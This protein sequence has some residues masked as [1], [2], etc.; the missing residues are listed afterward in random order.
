MTSSSKFPPL[1]KSLLETLWFFAQVLEPVFL[2]CS[3]PRRETGSP[4]VLRLSAGVLIS[5]LVAALA[6]AAAEPPTVRDA[7]PQWPRRAQPSPGAPNIVLVVLDDVGFGQL[8]SY[9]SPIA[10]P[11]FDRLAV[12][13]IRYTQFC[14]FPVCSPTRAALLTGRNPHSVGM[15]VITEL[16]NGFPNARGGLAPESPT[17][18]QILQASGYGTA[19]VGKW[20][21]I[22][23]HEQSPSSPPDNWPT[24]RGFDRFYGYLGG[25]TNHFAPDLFLDRHRIDP[26]A[27]NLDGSP[28]FLDADL[29]DRAISYLSDHHAA[30]P[31]RPFFLYLAYC[32]GHAPHHAPP[33]YLAQW[34]GRFDAGWDELRAAVLARQKALG[35]MPDSVRL[36]PHNPGVRPWSSLNADERRVFARYYE[37]FAANLEYTDRQFGRL[38]DFLTRSGQLENTLI[39][40]LS[41]NGA[42]PE[43][44]EQGLWNEMQ[45]FNAQRPGRL[46]EGLARLEDLGGPRSFGTYPLGFAQA[47][48]TPFRLTK[49]FPDAG[50][51]RVPLIFHWPARIRER[52]GIRGQFHFVTDV[53]AT[54][55]EAAGIE[56]S[57]VHRGA[58]A[59]PLHGVSLAY[60][61]A[62]ATAPTRRATQYFELYGRRAI[63]HGSWKAIARHQKGRPYSSDT[64]ELYDLA[65]DFAEARDV[66]AQFPAKLDELRAL[67]HREAESNGVYPLDDRIGERDL[68]RPPELGGARDRFV[69]FPPLEGQHKGTAPDLR[70]RSFTV[71]AWIAPTA[72]RADGVIVAQGGR[73][74][75]Y[76]FWLRHGH[77]VFDY[78][79]SGLERS[80]IASAAPLP[81]GPVEVAVEFRITP[82][83]GGGGEVTLRINGEIAGRGTVP[84]VMPGM[85]SHEP[86]D[87]GQ[88]TQT[89]VTEAYASPNRLQGRID[90]IEIR[91][92]PRG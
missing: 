42:S 88:D 8:G 3:E 53:T 5:L 40:L 39:V 89:P 49:G 36:P 57:L 61:W 58:P 9:G 67:W 83:P 44:G 33:E 7:T 79:L 77:L 2:S 14:T 56:P 28:Y 46:E 60:S 32:A 12:G 55:I 18:A 27:R 91:L 37:A 51:V 82:P 23:Q 73:F 22:P 43:G 20:H 85:I 24:G 1:A 64:W 52:G 21:L 70:G 76:S 72:A 4:I 65:S 81:A 6:L 71:T 35:L 29:T 11:N 50:G 84:R 86:L 34:R 19:A 62:S 10:T 47:G 68:L 63:Q 31:D 69:Y 15:G 38:L 16:A 59:P 87:F 90:R 75:G 41:D 92:Q 48:N 54:L 25:D 66:A 30:A 78:N 17:V 26:P 80:T 13:G 45:L 74:C